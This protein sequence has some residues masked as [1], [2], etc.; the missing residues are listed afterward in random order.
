MSSPLESRLLAP[1]TA[2]ATSGQRQRFDAS[3]S[4]HPFCRLCES[5]LCSLSCRGHCRSFCRHRFPCSQ[6]PRR[7][8]PLLSSMCLAS[9]SLLRYVLLCVF[10]Y[11][12]ISICSHVP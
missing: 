7:G 12:Y 2:T 1:E 4:G 5:S 10:V 8:V 9:R 3:F 6:W 11:C